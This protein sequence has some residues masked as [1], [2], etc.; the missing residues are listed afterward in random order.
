MYTSQVLVALQGIGRAYVLHLFL[1]GVS[2]E[3]HIKFSCCC[4]F[5][6]ALVYFSWKEML[7]NSSHIA[8]EQKEMSEQILSEVVF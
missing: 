8:P 1:Q 4:F 7:Q 6:F 5:L 2:W 3:G